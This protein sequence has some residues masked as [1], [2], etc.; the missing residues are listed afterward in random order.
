MSQM[1]HT[2]DNPQKSNLI[3]GQT[4]KA[5]EVLVWNDE[6]FIYIKYVT[7]EG[8]LITE[9]HCAVVADPN[10]FPTT[11]ADNPKIGKFEFSSEHDPGV[12]EVMHKISWTD[13]GWPVGGMVFIA[14][15]AVVITMEGDGW[16]EETAWGCYDGDSNSY[17]FEGKRWGCYFDYKIQDEPGEPG[18]P[19][20]NIPLD[21]VKAQINYEGGSGIHGDPSY[22]DTMLTFDGTYD[23]WSGFWYDGWC[24]DSNVIISPG[25]EFDV[26]L[27]LSTDPNIPWY[28]K[29]DEQWDKINY[30]L[31]QDYSGIG[32]TWK[33]IQCAIWALA[34]ATPDYSDG[35]VSGFDATIRDQI[36]NDCNTN[37]VGFFPGPGQWMAII[38]DPNDGVTQT[39]QL[40]FIV[41]D[42]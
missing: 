16:R 13:M 5:G 42:P 25:Q 22:F 26:K 12:T 37:G 18:K 29:D 38:V 35:S 8:W 24:A 39:I 4:D 2:A 34:D 33:E 40:S 11:G 15:H 17:D 3:A 32:A 23:V 28:A 36:I 27:Y 21:P 10:E 41:V 1:A 14:C 7:M 20:L 9:T 31:N 30:L 19:I 6:D